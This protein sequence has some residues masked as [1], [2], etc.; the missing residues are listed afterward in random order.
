LFGS[1]A[2]LNATCSASS[3]AKFASNVWT[4]KV[5][6]GAASDPSNATAIA[7]LQTAITLLN[8]MPGIDITYS[9]IDAGCT[10]AAW[11]ASATAANAA[12][13]CN[14]SA[15]NE[16]Y[17]FLN[18]PFSEIADLVGCAG[19]LGA[20]GHFA[21][22]ACHLDACSNRWAN[23]STP[24]FVMNNGTGCVGVDKYIAV[25]SH[26][27]LHGLGLGH[28]SGSCTA[29]MN[30]SVCNSPAPASS[31]NYSMSSLDTDCTDWMYRIA[32]ACVAPA[33]SGA[34]LFTQSS[35]G[36]SCTPTGGI[37]EIGSIV[38][39]GGSIPEYS[40]DGG[41]YSSTIPTY[42][43][44]TSITVTTR[45]KCADGTTGPVLV[46]STSPGVCSSVAA[47]IGSLTIIESTC[48]ASCVPT[49]GSIAQ[50]SKTC[51]SGTLQYSTDNIT[52]GSVV[53]TYNPT[54]A[55][56]V[57]TRCNCSAG[58]N[59][60]V[61]SVV[62]VPASCPAPAAPS[63]SFTSSAC[64]GCSVTG[65]AF[66]FPTPCVGSTLT[67]YTDI[68]GATA[69]TT[70]PVYNPTASMTIFYACVNATGCRSAIQSTT[71]TVGVC[72]TPTPP[73]GSLAI[74]ESS[75]G[76]GCT[77]SGG[78]IAIGTKTCGTGTLEYS[79]DNVV[80]T[81]S[82]P[83]YNQTTNIT[84]HTRCNCGATGTSVSNNQTTTVGACTTPALAVVGYNQ[85]GCVGCVATGGAFTLPI[86]CVGSTL[87]YYTSLSGTTL[88]A[89][90]V[91]NATTPMT[92]FY[93]CVDAN[94]CR[95]AVNSLTTTVANCGGPASAVVSSIPSICS[96]C[97]LL[98]GNFTT[99]TPCDAT[100]A[101]TYY[102]DATGITPITAP[103]YDQSY[104][105]TIY[106]ACVNTASGCRSAITTY[107]SVVGSCPVPAAP[108]GS[109]A[110]V[111]S[112]CDASC[113]STPGSIN[114]GTLACT[115]G[116]VEYSINGGTTWTLSPPGYNN[117]TAITFLVRCHC[118][119][120][121]NSPTQAFITAPNGCPGLL[122]PSIGFT[123]STCNSCV[124]SGGSLNTI[125]PCSGSALKF[126]TDA[127]G[128]TETATT[129]TYNPIA[130]I[131]IYYACVN[132]TTGCRSA[133]QALTTSIGSC[134]TPSAP[135]GS[136]A[137]TNSNC[138]SPCSQTLGSI[139][140]GTLA[141]ALS[142]L[143]YSSDGGTSWG[144]TLP[145]YSATAPVSVLARCSCSA[146]NNSTTVSFVTSP[147]SCITPSAP[148]NITITNNVCPAITGSTACDCGINTTQ[149]STNAGVTWSNA[150]PTYTTS[151]F[152]YLTR[153]INATGCISIEKTYT[154]AP[155]FCPTCPVLT[156]ATPVAIVS[157]ESVCIAGCSLQ[158]GSISAPITNCPSGSTL[159]YSTN[160]GTTWSTI[161]P[162]YNNTAIVTV[163]TRCLCDIDAAI[164][165]SVASASTNPGAC[166]SPAIP[167]TAIVNNV[168]PA[169]T[170]TI[171]CDCGSNTTQ[172]SIDAGVSWTTSAPTYTSSAVTFLSRCVNA[173]GCTS[174][175][176]SFSSSPTVCPVCP[177]FTTSPTVGV[178]NANCGADCAISYGTLIAPTSSCPTGSTLQ[179]S[180]NNLTWT[181]LLPTY[182]NT[183][184]MTIY[185]RCSCNADA[186]VTS[187]VASV[188]TTPI[189]CITPAPPTAAIVNNVCPATTG[190]IGCNCASGVAEYSNDG[191]TT[192]S[193][194]PPTYSSS[195]ISVLAHCINAQ[196]CA[197]N[198]INLIT[199]PNSCMTLTLLDNCQCNS[200]NV[201][202]IILSAN[203]GIAPYSISS[204]SA[205]NPATGLA[206][207][208][209]QANTYINPTTGLLTLPLSNG[210][211]TINISDNSGNVL[212]YTGLFSCVAP[213]ASL[214]SDIGLICT[215]D[216]SISL[217]SG[218]PIGGTYSVDGVPNATVN[219]A[220]LTAGTHTAT[221]TIT[222]A[223]AC[224]ATATDLFI[225]SPCFA[226]GGQVWADTINDNN[227]LDVGELLIEGV[228]IMIV[229]AA[230]GDTVSTTFTDPLGSWSVSDLP[231]GNYVVL[232]FGSALGILEGN[233]FDITVS[234]NPVTINFPLIDDTALPIAFTAFY[235]MGECDNTKLQWTVG[236]TQD[237]VYFSIMRSTDGVNYTTITQVPTNPSNS[238]LQ[239]FEFTDT[240]N[241]YA[242]TY[243]KLDMMYSNGTTQSSKVESVLADC[244]MQLV[245][246][247][248]LH[249]N[250]VKSDLYLQINSNIEGAMALE[251]Y[252]VTG[253]IIM[254]TSYN[255]VLGNNT[256]T[257][258]VISLAKGVYYLALTHENKR[259][260][261][262]K[263]VKK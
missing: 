251:V 77:L 137:I 176:I 231:N 216:P 74:V 244:D 214:S 18:D 189:V 37:I 241:A 64:S 166:V 126:Y 39:S 187:T 34:L 2:S 252:D 106:Y 44:T 210:S 249:P 153:C 70:A 53:P 55:V 131:T 134:P 4:V 263:F 222:D 19:T 119:A 99:P 257:L 181:T 62:T 25:L 233:S 190:S 121:S 195:P 207:S 93:A 59:S 255:V 27:M 94:G 60:T 167:V 49:G 217:S 111:Q 124:L 78:S 116:S 146:S 160:G 65:G 225:V 112:T 32:P 31:N 250:P 96:G 87:T 258:P 229:D 183:T 123:Q 243:Y 239:N 213:T 97:T 66:M 211:Y 201:L 184:A 148:S 248:N 245:E 103:L 20:G 220:T 219:P 5:A 41:A 254:T 159:Q 75:C 8:T 204:I 15:T 17:I 67:Y 147:V 169:I 48:N 139:S 30:P 175:S 156:G 143:Q 173:L 110:I 43:Q 89:T 52:Y 42:N 35:C 3:P 33:P 221:Y 200:S 130:P 242:T 163:S 47:P 170:G 13:I 224:S 85:S 56:T 109:P 50:G 82:I 259:M 172:Y 136:L 185:T 174:L 29:L 232:A 98:G 68:S 120:T 230:T 226:I 215:S 164:T 261:T 145:S 23:A 157:S 212:P 108:I 40:V 6:G 80:F 191:G 178:I 237:L 90:P 102:N 128:L 10:A 260:T 105:V 45:C 192:W 11:G 186:S 202:G 12:N 118:N 24:F 107:T 227:T 177:V 168:C 14:G 236:N 151:A 162:I 196:G 218:T 223:N 194:T 91:Y 205:T 125:T 198:Y 73:T 203:G 76:S 209:A 115:T 21:S 197:S 51:T 69:L 114:V 1:P 180:T 256:L 54:T 61:T 165:S 138:T 262:T 46:A 127:T 132:T 86:P 182:N 240:Y 28:I 57:Y 193:L 101:I 144:A 36:S 238:S 234:N 95:S 58:V 104:P 142:S 129:P 16:F 152:S 9:S 179:Y 133:I 188:V 150:A 122:N 247:I 71:T 72:G 228:V 26:E 7:D 149:Y 161:L 81:T 113:N 199:S 206:Y 79:T 235:V 253:R 117:S 88:A 63:V 92:I 140:I 22:S 135:T 84:V 83:T 154:T 141:C 38:C 100:S 171:A 246:I 158:S 208:I 155:S